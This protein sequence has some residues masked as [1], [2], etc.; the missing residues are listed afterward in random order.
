MNRL[1]VP[2]HNERSSTFK[3]PLKSNVVEV[4]RRQPQVTELPH[5]N[6]APVWLRSL[7]T[8]QRGSLILFGSAIG[9]SAIVYGH[10]A[11]TQ[12]LWKSQHQQLKRLQ[13][14][15]SQQ[16][17]MTENINYKLVQTAEKPESGFVAPSPVRSIFI[18]SAPQRPTK[19]LPVPQSQPK[20]KL[21]LGY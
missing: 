7:L 2:P 4:T 9:L 8:I 16:A 15:E 17:L 6:S 10:T 19:T 14:Q 1:N 20:S 5:H 21:P 18:L 11:R 12:D 3:V 13:A